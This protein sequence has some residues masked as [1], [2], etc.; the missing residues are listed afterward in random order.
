MPALSPFLRASSL[1]IGAAAATASLREELTANG[2]VTTQEVDA[3]YAVSRI[4]PGTNLLALY[5]ALGHRLGGW[6]LAIQAVLVGACVPAL[7]AVIVAYVYQHND[8][9]V[10][11]AL[12]RGARAG[13]VA[14]FLGAAIRLLKPQVKNHPKA[15]SAMAVLVLVA[16]I[17]LPERVFPVL[18]VSGVVGALGMKSR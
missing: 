3:A 18:V 1:H 17:A 9:S 10:V 13:G 12:M 14:V 7:V 15:G 16:A 8:S 5:A 2:D 11:S 4:T 6:N